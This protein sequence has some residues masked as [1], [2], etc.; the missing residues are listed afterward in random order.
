MFLNS[1]EVAITFKESLRLADKIEQPYSR[2]GFR[3]RVRIHEIVDEF[4]NTVLK[5]EKDNLIVLRGR[6]FA[7]EKLFDDP[8]DPTASGYKVNLN[9]TICLFGIGACGADV[10]SAP[11][12]PFTPIYSDE[13]LAIP[14]SFVTEDSTKYAD[15]DK[16]NNPSI[17]ESMSSEQKHIYYNPIIRDNGSTEYFSKIFEVNPQWIFNKTTNEVYKKIMLKLASNEA[18]GY[19]INELGLQ[20]AQYDS[21]NNVYSDTELFSRV[22]FD[23]ESL[24]SLTKALL[25]EYQVFA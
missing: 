21:I 20:I 8:I 18:R 22:T 5:Q 2:M 23:T 11:F 24:T 4:G 25:I 7:L 6:T 16:S 13:S 14:V 10:E 12:Q 3:G 19:M 9:R 15:Q 1:D 17:I